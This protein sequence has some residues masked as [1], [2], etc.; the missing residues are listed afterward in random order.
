[1]FLFV[2]RD[3]KAL[4]GVVPPAADAASAGRYPAEGLREG[5][6]LLPLPRRDVLPPLVHRDRLFRRTNRR[7]LRSTIRPKR[8]DS[9]CPVRKV[10]WGRELPA[11]GYRLI[12]RS[13]A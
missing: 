13:A 7:R 2:D 5:L 12:I 11:L 9:R 1:M 3:A 10:A 6:G 4:F 8:D